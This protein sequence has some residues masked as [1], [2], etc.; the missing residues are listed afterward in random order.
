L[1]YQ[2]AAAAAAAATATAATTILDAQVVEEQDLQQE[3]QEQFKNMTI[4]ATLVVNVSSKKEENNQAW[5]DSRRK[6]T[7]I[8]GTVAATL[9][10]LIIASGTIVG[11]KN[12]RPK[13]FETMVTASPTA[14]IS[15]W[16]FSRDIFLLYQ[17]RKLSWT[18]PCHSIRHFLG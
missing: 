9:I 2:D 11:T 3:V 13:P 7:V 5:A 18:S 16:D 15:I 6:S 4:D 10:I 1:S 17:E 14:S 12:L 8:I